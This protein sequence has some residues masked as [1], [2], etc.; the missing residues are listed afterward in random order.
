MRSFCFVID[1]R[2][3]DGLR[4]LPSTHHMPFMASS[5]NDRRDN[6]RDLDALPVGDINGNAETPPAMMSTQADNLTYLSR[7]ESLRFRTLRATLLGAW[8]SA[9]A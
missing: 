6:V 8:G 3:R 7:D 9:L 5:S 2:P 1:P 4:A